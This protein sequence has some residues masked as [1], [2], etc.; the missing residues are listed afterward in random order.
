MTSFR[1]GLA[2]TTLLVAVLGA[3][4]LLSAEDPPAAVSGKDQTTQEKPFKP[5]MNLE[6]L[7]EGQGQLFKAI[8]DGL[9]DQ[10]WDETKHDAWMLAELANTNQYHRKEAKYRE[11]AQKMSDQTVE[12]AKLLGKRKADEAKAQ[13][14]QIGQ[15]CKSCHEAYKKHR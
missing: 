9:A 15:T 6:Q 8:K 5:V 13:M 4:A 3:S 1:T 2:L 12:L 7:M 10:E 14:S 11:L